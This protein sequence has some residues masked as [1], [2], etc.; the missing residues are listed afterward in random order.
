MKNLFRILSY[1]RKY[2]SYALLNVVFNLLTV[3][4][5]SVF[6]RDDCAFFAVA[7]QKSANGDG[8]PDFCLF[9]LLRIR[10]PE[11]FTQP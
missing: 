7:F 9:G 8:A 5:S 11:I 2:T 6:G 1:I 3:V 10:I 4:F